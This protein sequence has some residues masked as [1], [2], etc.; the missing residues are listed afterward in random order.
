MS[1]QYLRRYTFR[2]LPDSPQPVIHVQESQYPNQV[3]VY[4]DDETSGAYLDRETFRALCELGAGFG[5]EISWAGL[6]SNTEPESND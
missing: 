5:N 2:A 4:T 3:H 6:P 1:R